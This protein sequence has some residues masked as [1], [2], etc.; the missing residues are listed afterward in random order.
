[1]TTVCISDPVH[2]HERI[3]WLK[4]NSEEFS[5][6][7]NWAAWQVGMDDIYVEVDS[8]SAMMYYLRWK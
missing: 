4:A 6:S 3:S 2:W 7:T 1:M 8:F 5:D